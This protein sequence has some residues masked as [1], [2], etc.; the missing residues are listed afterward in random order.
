VVKVKLNLIHICAKPPP[1]ALT[2]KDG[3]DRQQV[4][5]KL[6]TKCQPFV[7]LKELQ[8]NT[9]ANAFAAHLI[10]PNRTQSPP[11]THSAI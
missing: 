8:S 7:K 11:I 1:L 4:N 10:L 2:L 6:K 3:H 5:R 9:Q